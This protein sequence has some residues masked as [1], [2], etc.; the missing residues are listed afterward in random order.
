MTEPRNHVMLEKI[1]STAPEPYQEGRYVLRV[2]LT[3]G[4]VSGERRA[5][6]MA[7]N[8]LDGQRYLCAPNRRRDWVRNLL[9]HGECEIEGDLPT[10]YDAVLVEDA[11]AARV[12][13]HYLGLLNRVSNEW[14]FPAGASVTEIEAHTREIAV[15][16]LDGERAATGKSI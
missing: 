13:A 10:R 15:F 9:A 7:V 14:P 12:V 1:R 8:Q 3:T 6:P 4:R 5:A 2:L 11:S 16:R